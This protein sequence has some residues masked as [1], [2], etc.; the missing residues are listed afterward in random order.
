MG[1]YSCALK[2][3]KRTKLRLYKCLDFPLNWQFYKT[4]MKNVSAADTQIF[5][6]DN[7]WWLFTNI[8]ESQIEEHSSQLQIFHSE[9]S[10]EQSLDSFEEQSNYF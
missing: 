2:Q 10:F 1:S 6:F 9:S 5:F 4:I 3:I 7:K 8:D